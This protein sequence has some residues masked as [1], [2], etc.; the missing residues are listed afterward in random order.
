[1]RWDTDW[2]GWTRI[3][4]DRIRI[5][6]IEVK[7]MFDKTSRYAGIE[8]AK[9]TVVDRDGVKREV[10]YVRRRFL[11]PVESLTPIAEHI[12]EQGDRLDNLTAR[13]LGDP[14]QFWRIA[15]ANDALRPEELTDEVRSVVRIAFPA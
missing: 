9:L 11:P 6:T 3:F 15:D 1:M 10:K 7:N 12:V 8:E 4:A 13:Y 5:W 14:T 2:H